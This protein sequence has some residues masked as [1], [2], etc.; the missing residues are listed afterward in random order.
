MEVKKNRCVPHG[1]NG[2]MC[3]GGIYI[4]PME[5]DPDFNVRP[6]GYVRNMIPRLLI[7]F[8]RKDSAFIEHLQEIHDQNARK[9]LAD[10]KRELR[11]FAHKQNISP[12]K[13]NDMTSW[14]IN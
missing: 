3:P 2:R 11:E 8:N 13:I 4:E 6:F 9:T 7:K 14:E 5:M 12:A 1:D 10:I